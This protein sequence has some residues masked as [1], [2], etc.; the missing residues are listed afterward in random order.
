MSGRRTIFGTLINTAIFIILEVA[1]LNMLANNGQLQNFFI[2]KAAHGFMGKVWGASESIGSYFSLRKENERL[3]EEVFS[4][5]KKLSGWN[6]LQEEV[7]MDSL[8]SA[9][10]LPASDERFSFIPA[11]IIKSSRNKQHNYLIIGK[12]SE[13]GIRPQ[14][15]VVTA[16]GV[17]GIVDAVSRH[18][19]YAIS[20]LNSETSIS[21][22]IGNCGAVG[23]LVWDGKHYDKALMKE[24]PLQ[25]KFEPGDTVFT[26]G[27]S[28]IFPADIPMGT[29][30]ESKIVNGATYEIEVTLFQNFSAPRYVTVVNNRDI[31]E[32]ESL[33]EKAAGDRDNRDKKK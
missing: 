8:A 2:C 18:Y 23:P 19:S 5:T 33:E 27:F 13:D 22:R 24:I 1:A 29:V 14:S 30:G 12:G 32:I 3:S 16:N 17:V 25:Y 7:N 28:S 26:S 10:T 11:S 4:L 20:F 15:G 31:D 21:A 9:R 6:R